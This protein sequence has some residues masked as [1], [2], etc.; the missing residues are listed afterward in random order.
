MA[1][2]RLRVPLAPTMSDPRRASLSARLEDL[3]CEV[4]SKCGSL[5]AASRL[6]P[7]LSA[8]DSEEMLIL[9]TKEALQ[10]ARTLE[11]HRKDAFPR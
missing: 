5:R 9:M 2:G 8:Q 6:L 4:N 11:Q 1:P 10:L 3:R 7:G